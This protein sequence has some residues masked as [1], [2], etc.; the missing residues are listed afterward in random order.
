MGKDSRI[1]QRSSPISPKGSNP[2][3]ERAPGTKKTYKEAVL[4]GAQKPAINQDLQQTL[5]T[6][7]Q[8]VQNLLLATTVTNRSD[9]ED[10]SGFQTKRRGGKPRGGYKRYGMEKRRY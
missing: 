7:K 10:L 1:N 9:N 8:V 4:N 3:N 5:Q 6:L 2:K